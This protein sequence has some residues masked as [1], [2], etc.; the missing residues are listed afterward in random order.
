MNQRQM[1]RYTHGHHPSVVSQHGTRSVEDSAQFLLPLLQPHFKL[2]DVGCGPGSITRGFTEHVSEVYGVDGS[3]D[4]I[5]QAKAASSK[6]VFEVASAYK[7][8]A[9]SFF[10]K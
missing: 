7:L 9:G 2:L 3:E 4:V 8:S 1:E 6:V 5:A 10:C